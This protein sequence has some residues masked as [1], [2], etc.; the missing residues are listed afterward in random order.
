[1]F[2]LK[3]PLMFKSDQ[4]GVNVPKHKSWAIQHFDE[5][6]EKQLLFSK[7]CKALTTPY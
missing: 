3:I 6:V 1:M 5:N 2:E 4:T 7:T